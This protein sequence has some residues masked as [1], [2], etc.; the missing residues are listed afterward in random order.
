MLRPSLFLASPRFSAPQRSRAGLSRARRHGA[1]HDRRVRGRGRRPADGPRALARCFPRRGF[2]RRDRRARVVRFGLGQPRLARRPDQGAAEGHRSRVFGGEGARRRDHRRRRR[3]RGRGRRDRGGGRRCAPGG[4]VSVRPVAS[5]RRRAIVPRDR[6]PGRARGPP[7]EA[8]E[9]LGERERRAERRRPRRGER[10]RA[11]PRRRPGRGGGEGAPRGPRRED[12][13]RASGRRRGGGRPEPR[14]QRRPGGRP[15]V[16]ALR[17]RLAA[18]PGEGLRGRPPRAPPVAQPSPQ[19]RSENR[20][21]DKHEGATR[22]G[23]A[24]GPALGAHRVA[25]RSVP[26]PVPPARGLA[27]D[28]EAAQALRPPEGVPG[29]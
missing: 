22:G 12:D 13:G 16:R 8:P 4:R 3:G 23:E 7:A 11:R 21:Q 17:R 20:R 19:V 28:E 29:V 26:A 9:S 25:R 18:H 6:A 5:R 10:A 24:Q 14:G 2:E 15:A 27:P 1:R